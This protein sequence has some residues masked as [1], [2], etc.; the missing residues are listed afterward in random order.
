MWWSISILPQEVAGAIGPD[1]KGVTSI[2]DAKHPEMRFSFRDGFL[3]EDTQS[4]R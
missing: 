3:I 4:P 1:A 2:T